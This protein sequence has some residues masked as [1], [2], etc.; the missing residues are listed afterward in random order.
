MMMDGMRR[1]FALAL[2][3]L[4]P[5][6]GAGAQ[7]AG[8]LRDQ[9]MLRIAPSLLRSDAA[10]S[11]GLRWAARRVFDGAVTHD[12]FPRRFRADV[13]T[14]G[15]AALEPDANPE[16][17]HASLSAGW[18]VALFEPP[19]DPDPTDPEAAP[20]G[21]FDY[22]S[23][24]MGA[25]AEFESDQ[26]FDEVNAVLGARMAY[27]N[28]RQ[29][30]PWPLLP[31]VRLEFGAVL[32]LATELSERVVAHTRADVY[33]AWHV[34]LFTTPLT[35]HAELW[36][37]NAFGADGE[38]AA[39]RTLEGLFGSVA[40]AYGFSV[41]LGQLTVHE[42]FV[43]WSGGEAPVRATDRRSWMIGIVVGG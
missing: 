22:G 4:I 14:E 15:T 26:L 29:D 31:G 35:V 38:S 33:A 42:V 36:Y 23:V 21:G 3:W 6:G 41:P 27:V 2:L 13:G 43:R 39:V 17:I 25:A 12:R 20:E 40:L 7:E 28:S 37:W 9:S 32:P 19:T 34:P 18:F 24:S 1:G 10:T 16:T 5:V 30:F 8:Y 11:I